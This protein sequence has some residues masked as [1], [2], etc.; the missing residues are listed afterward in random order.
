M[1][2]HRKSSPL[3]GGII[4]TEGQSSEL[5]TYVDSSEAEW[6]DFRPGSRR[7]VLYENP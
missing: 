6:Q 1:C 5:I 2:E 7:E 3:E 4:M